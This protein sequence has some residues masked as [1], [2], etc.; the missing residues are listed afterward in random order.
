MKEIWL[1]V[2]DIDDWEIRKNFVVY[3]IEKNFDGVIVRQDDVD[4]IRKLGKIKIISENL[5]SD[6]VLTSSDELLK[7][8]YGK[9]AYYKEIKSKADERNVIEMK[10]FF[11]YVIIKAKD[12]KVIPLENL[13]AEV[14]GRIIME[15]D[16]YDDAVTSLNTL[17]A[18]AYGVSVRTLNTQ[19]IKK[20]YDYVRETY[21]ERRE[22]K[23]SP[24]RITNIKKLDIGDRV[25]VDTATILKIGEGMLIGSQS[26]GLFLVHSE[27]VESEYVST[28][29]F[30]VNA[31]AVA[32]YILCSEKTKYLSELECGDEVLI[33]DWKGNTRKTYVVRSKIE[34]RPLILIEATPENLEEQ[35]NLSKLKIMLQNAETVRLV[36]PDG[37][38][39]SVSELNIGDRVLAYIEA[40]GRHFGTKI[41]ETI[42]EK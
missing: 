24:V 22:I 8:L 13:I 6:I 3:A 28:R 40:G 30:R 35:K 7:R 39:I 2:R 5:N 41:E 11:D 36:T 20:I 33:V 16:N 15:V 21:I 26:N 42:I 32:S 29:P 19:E 31:G 25:C 34:R 17:E 10:N 38:P 23:L 12:W 4:K 37:K 1:D 9:R 18:G 27:T 14:K